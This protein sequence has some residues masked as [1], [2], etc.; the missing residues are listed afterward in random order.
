[1]NSTPAHSMSD[2]V[3][4][5]EHASRAIQMGAGNRQPSDRQSKAYS[6]IVIDENK[7]RLKT[8]IAPGAVIKGSLEVEE[9]ARIA[10][11]VTGDLICSHGSAVI[12]PTGEVLGSLHASERVIVMGGRVGTPAADPMGR[13][14]TE[15]VCPGDVILIGP[16]VANVEAYFGTLNAYDG[17]YIDGG[18]HPYNKR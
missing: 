18:A 2:R 15:L 1:M 16:G 14:S 7:D 4:S 6:E 13:P 5:L 3:V 11:T 9:G 12:E 10:G 8:Y 17:G